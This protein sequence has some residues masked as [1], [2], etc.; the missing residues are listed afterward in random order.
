MWSLLASSP[1]QHA[2]V[3]PEAAEPGL[4]AAALAGHAIAE[5]P[6]VAALADCRLPCSSAILTCSRSLSRAS[7]ACKEAKHA[8]AM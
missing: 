2:V 5:K 6:S 3:A 1:V 8:T 4:A 7:Y